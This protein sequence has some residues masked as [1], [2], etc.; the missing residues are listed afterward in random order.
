MTRDL[1]ALPETLDGLR[2]QFGAPSKPAL[3][4][5]LDELRAQYQNQTKVNVDPTDSEAGIGTA[6]WEGAKSTGR[7]LGSAFDVVT[8]D[9]KEI[10]EDAKIAP[11][12]TQAQTR[13]NEA[14]QRN[15][16]DD[17]KSASTLSQIGQAIGNVAGAVYE[18]P[19]GAFHEVAAQIPNSAA[20]MAPMFAGAALG[21]AAGPIGA[22]VGGLAGMFVGNS[23]IET[24]YIAQ[25]QARRG[26]LD[27]GEALRQGV[28]KGGVITGVD[29][30]TI[31]LNKYLFGNPGKAANKA[32]ESLYKRIGVDPTDNL[33]IGK[34]L[35]AD[36]GLQ[37]AVR[38]TGAEAF[39]KAL[40]KGKQAVARS[41]L[42]M[43][44]ESIGEGTG[45]YLGSM[46]AGLDAS[47]TEAALEAML[48]L[49]QSAAEVGISAA[50]G[51]QERDLK[52]YQDRYLP[53][54]PGNRDAPFYGPQNPN[55]FQGPFNPADQAARDRID[56]RVTGIGVE[57]IPDI[58]V[59]V[60]EDG[61][62]PFFNI[63]N[64]NGQLERV[65][66]REKI[67]RLR[68]D[69]LKNFALMSVEQQEQANEQL[70]QL[71]RLEQQLTG[72]ETGI[73][74]IPFE[75]IT[76]EELTP[77]EAF[78]EQ[79][80][81]VLQGLQGAFDERIKRQKELDKQAAF[82]E[83]EKKAARQKERDE[84]KAQQELQPTSLKGIADEVGGKTADLA[85]ELARRGRE[86]AE[87]TGEATERSPDA[88]LQDLKQDKP[89]NTAM[90]DALAKAKADKVKKGEDVRAQ[91][92]QSSDPFIREMAD[93]EMPQAGP[94]RDLGPVT[95]ET[96][97]DTGTQ[98]PKFARPGEN[99]NNPLPLYSPR[100]GDKA[101]VFKTRLE[102]LINERVGKGANGA[103]LSR[104][105]D[106]WARK[107]E[108][109]PEE[110]EYVPIKKFLADNPGKVS[111][112]QLLD[113]VK[114]NQPQLGE[115]LR[116]G[117]SADDPDLENRERYV[118][119]AMEN[120]TL[121]ASDGNEFI[122][123]ISEDGR[124]VDYV[125]RDLA[126]REFGDLVNDEGAARAYFADR[127]SGMDPDDAEAEMQMYNRRNYPGK[128]TKY[129]QWMEPGGKNYKELLITKSGTVKEGEDY[130]SGHWDEKN[131][132]AHVRFD[133]R[134]GKDGE[135]VL[136]LEEVQSDW[137]QDGRK[138]G[139]KKGIKFQKFEPRRDDKGEWRVWSHDA[140]AFLDIEKKY[141]SRQQIVDDLLDL[142]LAEQDMSA[143]VP[144]APFKKT[145][146][147][148]AMK[149]M[150]RYAAD[151]GFDRIAWADGAMNADRYDLRKQVGLIEY[152]NLGNKLFFVRIRDHRNGIIE[153]MRGA[154]VSDV[155]DTLGKD[156]A[157]QIV[158]GE[159]KADPDEP[160]GKYLE[161]EDLKIGGEGMKA[162]YDQ[163]LPAE[164]NKYAKKFGVRVEGVPIEFGKKTDGTAVTMGEL[165][166]AGFREHPIGRMWHLDDTITVYN[167][168]TGTE[169]KFDNEKDAD[170]YA[171]EE[172]S[173]LLGNVKEVPGFKVTDEMK[174]AAKEGQLMFAP[175]QRSAGDFKYTEA[176]DGSITV[177]GDPAEIRAKL[178]DG[179]KGRVTKEGLVFSHNAAPRVKRALAGSKIAYSRGGQVLRSKPMKD[180]KY[181]GA[182]EK[183]N[184]KETIGRLR[185]ILRKLANEGALGRHWYENSSREV[186]RAA[187]GDI[188]EARKF[189][190]LLAIYSPQ[191]K[192]DT[193][194][195]FAIRAW[196]Q[197]R[198]GQPINVKTGKQDEAAQ[199]ALDDI[200]A[201]WS[202]Q[203]TGNFFFNLLREIDP[204]TE[205]QQGATIDMWMMRAAQYDHDMPTDLEYA[206]MEDEVNILAKKLGWE[207]QQVQAA[208][209]VAMKARMENK[210]VKARTERISERKGWIS[211]EK[212]NAKTGKK[213]GRKVHD[214][215]AH[216]NNWLK[217]SML[218]K[219]TPNDSQRAKFDFADGMLRHIGQVSWEPRIST[220]LPFMPGIHEAS[221]EQQLE[222]FQ[223]VK[224]ALF[225]EN[226]ADLLAMRLGLLV[227]SSITGPGVWEGEVSPSGQDLIVMAPAKGGVLYINDQETLT[228]D[229]W[230][231]RGKPK[232]FD[233]VPSLDPAQKAQLDVYASILGLLLRQDGVGY[234]RAFPAPSIKR[235]N[236]ITLVIGRPFSPEEITGLEQRLIDGVAQ[237]GGDPSS[238]GIISTPDGANVINFGAVEDNKV[239]HRVVQKAAA[240]P[241]LPDTDFHRFTS[242]GNLAFNNW[243]VDTNGQ[244]Y[245][246]GIAAA[247]S[248]D[249]L[250]WARD[251][252]APRIQAVNEEYAKKFG[253]GDPGQIRLSARQGTGGG[254]SQAGRGD[255]QGR[256]RREG[257]T[258]R[259]QSLLSGGIG[260]DGRN[261]TDFFAKVSS[262]VLGKPKPG[263]T[264]KPVIPDTDERTSDFTEEYVGHR[265]HFDDHIKFSIPGF[266]ELQRLVGAALARTYGP[267]HTL[268]DI[269]ASEGAFMK[270]VTQLSG[271]KSVAVDPNPKMVEHFN[272]TPVK[273][274]EYRSEAFGTADQVGELAW[275]EDDGTE[276]RYFDPAGQRYDV[277]HEAMVFQFISPERSTQIARVK[278]LMT[279]DGVAIFEEKVLVPGDAWKQNEAQKNA[280]KLQY[281][282][283]EALDKKAVE[284]LEGMN[285]NMVRPDQLEDTLAAN[286]NH[287]V[288]FW[289]SGNFKGY[290]A[291]DSQEKLQRLLDEI[292]STASEYATVD[293]PR[294][295]A[296]APTASD[297][298]SGYEPDTNQVREPRGAT[299]SEQLDLFSPAE[300]SAAAAQARDNFLLGYKSV[301]V[302]QIQS[303]VERVT[304]PEEAAHVLAP[305]RKY[306][307]EHMAIL[308]LDEQGKPTQVIQHTVGAID[309]SQVYPTTLVGAVVADPAATSVWFA[310]NHPSGLPRPSDADRRIT[311]VITDM[312][313]GT[314]VEVNGHVI[315]AS[316]NSEAYYL[317]QYGGSEEPVKIKPLARR[318]T[319][320]VTERK[321]R[322]S[323]PKD[324]PQVTGPD[325]AR[326]LV[327]KV[328][329]ADAIVLLDNQH[330]LVGSLTLTAEEMGA[331]RNN[332]QVRRIL[333]AIDKANAAAA[334]IKA[335]DAKGATNVARFLNQGRKLR[336][337][338]AFTPGGD[339]T[340][341][342]SALNSQGIETAEGPF[343]SPRQG[344]GGTA[345]GFDASTENQQQVARLN[346]GL[347]FPPGTLRAAELR[348]PA[349][350][351]LLG[352][353]ERLLG[354]R[355][356]PIRNNS[357]DP[358]LKFNG[359]Y[360]PGDRTTLF[361]D[362]DADSPAL[363]VLG[364]E[365]VHSLRVNDPDTFYEIA[366]KILNA[367]GVTGRDVREYTDWVNS[368]RGNL[369]PLEQDGV[370]EEMLADIFGDSINDSGFWKRLEKQD[371]T[372][373]QQLAT[374]LKAF[375]DRLLSGLTG[376]PRL[377]GSKYVK[378]FEA[379]RDVVAEF[380]GDYQG[381]AGPF[382]DMADAAFSGRNQQTNAVTGRPIGQLYSRVPPNKIP[383]KTR[384]VY[385]LMR[386][387]K[388]QPGVVYPLYAKPETGGSAGY[389]AGEWFLAEDQKVR[390][391]N[392]DLAKRPGIHAV[393]LPVFD[394][395]KAYVKGETRVWVEVEIPEVTKKTQAESDKSEKRANGM[396]NGIQGRLIGPR[397]SYD[398]KT[399]PN[400]S[401]DAGGWPIA[402]SMRVVRIL[403]DREV[404]K[405]LRDNNLSHQ[406]ENSSTGLTSAEV[407]QMNEEM[408]QVRQGLN[409]DLMF[410]PR[411]GGQQTLGGQQQ[412]AP[413]QQQQT[414]GGQ[415]QQQQQPAPPVQATFEAPDEIAFLDKIKIK[416]YEKFQSL[417]NVQKAIGPV[418][419][420]KDA[421]LALTTYP[422]RV[423]ARIDEFEA[424]Y[425]DPLKEAIHDSGLSFKDI[426]EY[427]HARHAQSAN[428]ALKNRNPGRPNNDRLSGMTDQDARAILAQ[429]QGDVRMQR[430]VD[431][432]DQ[433][434][435]RRM[436]LMV[437]EGLISQAEANAWNSVWQHYVPLHREESGT[438]LPKRGQGFDVRGKESRTRAGSADRPVDHENMVA[439]ILTQYE[440]ALQRAEKNK[441]AQT[442]YRL[443]K[444]NPNDSFWVVDEVPQN[445]FLRA[446][447]TIGWRGDYI[448]RNV[449]AAKF[450]GETKYVTFNDA[451]EH[452]NQMV[453]ALK[454]LDVNSARILSPLLMINRFLAALNT[455]LSP[456][457]VISNF[458]RD[459]QT[460]G[461][462]LTNTELRDMKGK[463]LRNTPRAVKGIRNALRGDGTDQWAS[464]FNRF[465]E[466]GGITGWM[467]SYD[468]IGDRLK[469]LQWDMKSD[470]IQGIKQLKKFFRAIEDYNTI[471]E[472]GVRL[473]AFK[474]AIDAGMSD[475][476]AAQLAKE[477]TVNFNRR[478]EWG[479]AMNALYLFYNAS[480]QGSVRMLR[481]IVQKDN[482]MLHKMLAAT[483]GFAIAVELMNNLI[484]GDDDEY[485]NI[486]DQ[487]KDRNLVIMDPFELTEGGYFKI[488]LPWGYNLFHIVGQEIAKATLAAA[489][490]KPQ[491]SMFN[492]ASRILNNSLQAFNPVQDGSV[493]QTISPTIIDPMTRIAE[494]KDWHG[495]RLYPDYNEKQANYLKHFSNARE[496]SKDIAKWLHEAT[497]DPK[498]LSSTIDISPEWID[499]YIDYATGSV[500]RVIT[501]AAG[502]A[503]AVIAGD[504]MPELKRVPI[505]R[506]VYQSI[507]DSDRQRM[508]YERYHEMLTIRQALSDAP[509][510][511]T[512]QRLR[513]G[514]GERR[515]LLG[516]TRITQSQLR[517]LAKQIKVAK[518]NGDKERVK[519]LENR[520]M[521]VMDRFGK[522]Y[523]TVI[524]G[525][526]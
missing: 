428:L 110:L 213:T 442:L 289:D 297:L 74:G 502:L 445:P 3:P 283:K 447:H 184:T 208:I 294:R 408:E 108:I 507:A 352:S 179:V 287:V 427:L 89:R 272:K 432:I 476:K 341:V 499:M 128:A 254:T 20:V 463:V 204:S 348:S 193:N 407:A 214:K 15:E 46:A 230:E 37:R 218:H 376:V 158:N 126:E 239:F 512:K 187:G 189:V 159:G 481:A 385:K 18:Q 459:W 359:V 375:V 135:K 373:A 219:V 487:V 188:N 166:E 45:E 467:Q 246:Q 304:S 157:K 114:K 410:S 379:V 248:S 284:V 344:T 95:E 275:T 53:P 383:T 153:T 401:G 250:A 141:T 12:Y 58:D 270:A 131:V 212:V 381:G 160:G 33:A 333:A 165:R 143:G 293:T 229:E 514:L 377:Q 355:I 155:E 334:I 322:K 317:D 86:Q 132:L 453:G 216:W 210:Q 29:A 44:T 90:A 228:K 412:Q 249:V 458:F 156:I 217:Q 473:S 431:L 291:S 354:R 464:M 425:V 474:A 493:L 411:Q 426:G 389:T 435:D 113:F 378:D 196:A 38:Q 245:R 276:I 40:P 321:I 168:A 107:G 419:E 252:L 198:M 273:G 406:I 137:H 36:P 370:L 55:T 117:P 194:T 120:F 116:E 186:L 495:G 448:N 361:I 392:K 122:N 16:A 455:S 220:K 309:G 169:R 420:D 30:A 501:D 104:Q 318:R 437:S 470:R 328:T 22:I 211:Y 64:E 511:K 142:R 466:A 386:V 390:I 127:Y 281:F 199:K 327:E 231:S 13:F 161:A 167:T 88:A 347:G 32:I 478:G 93:V 450:N 384:T 313:D 146:P 206:F 340:L 525:E 413:G 439:R 393:N 59:P 396:R 315:L 460:A 400:A 162:F 14:V 338:D 332:N 522:R 23:A 125:S 505:A 78:S 54:D 451:N 178:P 312:F 152:E 28:V 306:G 203:K 83:A 433:I 516:M 402:G 1:S 226:G 456:E 112:E 365:F 60:V 81:P 462:N 434:Q 310:H 343:L 251:V 99:P 358:N 5:T 192:V 504:E 129:D 234:H 265:G 222:Y 7:A 94:G 329:S 394:Q 200:D 301:Q 498:T 123:V 380:L 339:G 144:D 308:V 441:V 34:A 475:A 209:W 102:T 240:D 480:I 509:D 262:G 323:P 366:Q 69:L 285:K 10:Y 417:L 47:L 471:V 500:G 98:V 369:P 268:L 517:V 103:A 41:A 372:L 205:G 105:I 362:I 429:Y 424:A 266:G 278:E 489:G 484:D 388:R 181:L 506:K 349:L 79:F 295:V 42:G 242:D 190:A 68:A 35:A 521:E 336:V 244:G 326:D 176:P 364:H 185:R 225:D 446:D 438:I 405:I 238:L 483:V 61:S 436:D 233:K 324:R 457:F 307:Q 134:K 325:I 71:Q 404:S 109:K 300:V 8:G 223:A 201:F 311:K 260:G 403:T 267:E 391:G 397:E 215:D 4:A 488:P 2:Q 258:D 255:Q 183:Y 84:V 51:S 197:H 62:S 235:A 97:A 345:G 241:S 171:A 138:K 468:Q 497:L 118:R 482:R 65:N 136:F 52:N 296:A 151:N 224:N 421:Q 72:M 356:I 106:A 96:L 76:A 524:Y 25:D 70:K 75:E 149:R 422:G 423:R 92:R 374:A 503:A 180:G 440:F 305:L 39:I 353:L 491:Y 342:S 100:Q 316:A 452:A 85:A 398:F 243:E 147:M 9:E 124:T 48:S 256:T 232:G 298:Y 119:H 465:R 494:N 387:A 414:P 292:G 253:W 399:N 26:E 191:A 80:N 382:A 87:A 330:G 515:K 264:Y 444:D 526:G 263:V 49:P 477:L 518:K 418:S 207:P 57:E 454:N 195:T 519:L 182:P 82:E 202:G 66:P 320:P 430:V 279:D 303:G 133:E 492:S 335:T 148:L 368:R 6:L 175:R 227:D 490:E 73:S 409:R 91:A 177:K 367:S 173:K 472:N 286:F 115:V 63:I 485:D 350:R 170:K 299:K 140:N 237:T 443:A 67:Q 496:S 461:Y 523:F 56:P 145:W 363:A 221:Y 236:G 259:E 469:A 11:K 280:H 416:L 101:P 479:V 346:R 163:I 513:E 415:Q 172:L 371:K 150:I 277:I 331:L 510:L 288:Q 257:R 351:Q 314:G 319:V 486:P 282:D 449:L 19:R 357:T 261:F 271:M 395:G 290:I 31:G 337:L 111:K 247:G 77:G 43:T 360:N 27:T 269:G 274:A 154:S 302:G 121:R 24:G 21:A 17:D 50:L 130:R 174:Q 520:R 508:F 164:V 139:Y